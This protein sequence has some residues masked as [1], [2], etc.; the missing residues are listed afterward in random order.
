MT[1]HDAQ[2]ILWKM[3]MRIANQYRALWCIK[4]GIELDV[5][6]RKIPVK[7]LIV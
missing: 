5:A 2:Y 7:Q 4:H 3:D 6:Q 1:N